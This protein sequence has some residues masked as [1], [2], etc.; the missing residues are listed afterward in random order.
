MTQWKRVR[1]VVDVPVR[2]PF[3]FTEKDLAWAVQRA[4]ESDGFWQDR[5]YLPK[6]QQPVFGRVEVKEFNRVLT[7]MKRGA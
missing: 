1:A 2:A 5:K 6:E 3:G 7:A 4:L